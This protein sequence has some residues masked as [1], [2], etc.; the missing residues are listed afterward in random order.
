V[1][2]VYII[3]IKI[4]KLGKKLK[5]SF[6]ASAATS[7]VS[8]AAARLVAGTSKKSILPLRSGGTELRRIEIFSPL[9]HPAPILSHFFSP[10]E[11]IA[12]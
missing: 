2:F 5:N 8:V 4:R 3:Y 11:T 7:A 1:L 6:Y 9:L 12:L 10:T